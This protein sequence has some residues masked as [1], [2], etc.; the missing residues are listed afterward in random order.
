MWGPDKT[1][2]KLDELK[3]KA[4]QAVGKFTDNDSDREEGE[5]EAFHGR[6]EQAGAQDRDDLDNPTRL[7]NEG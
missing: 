3:G 1:K 5:D 4:K 2:G 7:T 6:A